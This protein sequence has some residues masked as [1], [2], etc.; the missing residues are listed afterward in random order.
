MSMCGASFTLS[1][2]SHLGWPNNFL[3]L[4]P[5]ASIARLEGWI[6]GLLI[7]L[8]YGLSANPRYTCG[9]PPKFRGLAQTN[10]SY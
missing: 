2:I 1:G 5:Q 7:E 3:A 10:T 4:T 9:T 6:L 8:S